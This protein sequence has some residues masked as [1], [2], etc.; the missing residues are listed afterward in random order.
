MTNLA[1][2]EQ[3]TKKDYYNWQGDWELIDGSAYAMAPSPFFSHQFV[4]GKIYRQLD[5]KLDNCKECYAV[6]ETDLEISNS[7]ILRPDTMIICYEPEDRLT[8]T[9]E[10][11]FEVVSNSSTRRDEILKFT[12][13]QE[14]GIKYYILV[15]PDIKKAKVYKLIDFKYQ[16]IGDF[17]DE[18]YEFALKNCAIEFDFSF[19]WKK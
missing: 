14:E 18:I 10:L 9:P 7:T 12:I 19:I 5:E 17:S 2:S 4:N 15:Y 13:Y 8:K 1:Y 11:I 6:I 3:Y 16:K